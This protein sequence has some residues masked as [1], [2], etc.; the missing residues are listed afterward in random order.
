MNSLSIRSYQPLTET[1]IHDWHQLVLPL[2]GSIHIELEGY[3]GLVGVGECVVIRSGQ[4]HD[5][6]ANEAA[7]FVVADL[8]EL[9]A[10][11]ADTPHCLFSINPPLRSFLLF[12]EQQLE[13]RVDPQVEASMVQLFGQ[14]LSQQHM[15]PPQDRLISAIQHWITEQLHTSLGINEL[16][17]QAGLG[18]T[19]FK[20]RFREQLGIS[21][22]QYIT[23]ERMEKAR[24][25]LSHTD[26]SVQ[27]IAE[28]IGYADVSAFSR[29]F[30]QHFGLPPRVFAQGHNHNSV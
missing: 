11:L 8:D 14:L 1:H 2:Q 29:R 19:Q 6:G 25:L 24:A 16:A 5:F 3:R 13:Y 10:P 28:Q 23:R 9:P 27:Q 17:R 30:S 20:K 12:V 26:L 22:M 15:A 18:T 4:R 7:R 21:P